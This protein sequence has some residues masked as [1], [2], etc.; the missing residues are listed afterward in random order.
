MLKKHVIK[1]QAGVNINFTYLVKKG[2][3]VPQ[4]TH[5]GAGGEEIQLLLINDL[6]TRL[7]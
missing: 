4:H 3:A 5:R 1:A 6:G 2:K 7:E